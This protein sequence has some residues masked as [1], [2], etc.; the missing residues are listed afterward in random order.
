MVKCRLMIKVK[1]EGGSLLARA[2]LLNHDDLFD[3][4]S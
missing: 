3:Q 4:G 1:F 2:T